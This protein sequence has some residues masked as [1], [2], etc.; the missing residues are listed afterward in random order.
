MEVRILHKQG[1][2]LREISRLTGLSRNTV[3]KYL[4]TGEGPLF[5]G[6]PVRAMK[7][8]P[9]TEYLQDRVA[10]ATPHW[11]PA[12]V[13]MGELKD[14]GYLGG[15]T[16]L[17][18]YLQTL[19]AVIKSDPVVRYETDP[20]QQMQVDWAVLRRGKDPLSVFVAVLGYSRYA[21]VEFV[22]N[23]KSETLLACHL[24]ALAF[25]G[26]TPRTV[27][28]D[29]MRTV[30]SERDAYGDGQ[31]RFNAHFLD[32]AG[33]CGFKPKLCRPYRAKTKG[34]VERFIR[35]LRYSFWVPLESKLRQA[36]L[37]MDATSAN[38]EAR[39]WLRDIANVRQVGGIGIIPA[40]AF[41]LD[42]A[43]LQPVPKPYV[44]A[45]VRQLL[46]DVPVKPPVQEG[47]ALDRAALKEL[48]PAALLSMP[49][50]QRP[51]AAYDAL[52]VHEVA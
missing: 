1:K 27:L 8:D 15:I 29:N 28:Y 41:V 25:F 14:R 2:S 18:T 42:Q 46:A 6:R 19:R 17:R 23:E 51:L 10:A 33:H 45:S 52:L 38:V 16:R 43:A 31:H 36:G 32:F 21:Y 4:A 37:R 44:G 7:L 49:P 24:N 22:T 26:G 13:L 30:V 5:K 39:R 34:K 12:T 3:A 11:I 20:G 35:Y 47:P 48:Y 40:E 9:H 50:I